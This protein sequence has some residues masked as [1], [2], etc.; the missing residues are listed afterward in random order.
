M[1]SRDHRSCCHGERIARVDARGDGEFGIALRCAAVED[2]DR[3]A[4]TRLRLYAGCGIVAGS[5][6]EGEI[7]ESEAKLD[8][9]RRALAG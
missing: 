8:A 2:T 4:A 5:T 3:G 9:V 1:C 7:A 6:A